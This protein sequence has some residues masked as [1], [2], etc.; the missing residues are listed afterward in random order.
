MDDTEVVIIV[1][2]VNKF[3]AK[4]I[5]NDKRACDKQIKRTQIRDVYTYDSI[6]NF[7]ITIAILVESF[8]MPHHFYIPSVHKNRDQYVFKCKQ[9][10][11]R[12]NY[13]QRG[14]AV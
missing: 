2:V 6:Q 8:G 7:N 1:V 3:L 13:I 5:F 12:S 14:R 4:N 9:T 11:K 10:N